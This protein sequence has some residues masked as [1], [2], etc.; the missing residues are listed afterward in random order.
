MPEPR[1]Q[2]QFPSLLQDFPEPVF[3]LDSD[4]CLIAVNR[5]AERLLDREQADLIGRNTRDLLSPGSHSLLLDQMQNAI[6]G[7]LVDLEFVNV[8]RG[9]IPVE[10][11]GSRD[12]SGLVQFIA[13]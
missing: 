11:Y 2:I 13:R 1:A 10:A 5:A 3:V 12:E 7:F 8:S 4:A 9:S 6:G